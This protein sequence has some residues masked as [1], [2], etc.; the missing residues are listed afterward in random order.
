VS[1]GNQIVNSKSK[2]STNGLLIKIQHM[3][4]ISTM[5]IMGF[6]LTKSE[7]IWPSFG[8]VKVLSWKI[9]FKFLIVCLDISRKSFQVAIM[10]WFF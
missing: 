2:K 3:I 4:D 5:S 6:D 8:P 10:F 1:F 7:F 9:N